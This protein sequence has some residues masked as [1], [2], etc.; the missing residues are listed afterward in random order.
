MAA[1]T[2][3]NVAMDN[4]AKLAGKRILFFLP[5]LE[6]GGAE[7]QALH[8]ARYL[9]GFGCDVRVWGNSG[10]GLA[11]DECD[12][13]GIPWAIQPSSWPCRKVHLVRCAWRLIKT[14]QA[15]RR[16]RPDVIFAYCA[17][18]CISS[19]LVWRWSPVKA[20]IWGQRDIRLRGDVVERL[21]YRRAS[22]VVCN[23]AHELDYLNRVLGKGPSRVYVVPNGIDIVPSQETR[24]ES[25]TRLGI[26]EDSLAVTM[27]ANFRSGK[28]HST[29]LHAWRRVMATCADLQ[30]PLR[31]VLA[32]AQQESYVAIH[33]LAV[34]LGLLQSVAFL[35]QVKD[36]AGLLA[37]SDVGVLA[38][39]DE[40][41]PN[42]VLEY[43][44][45][46]LPIIA[47]DIPGSRE[48]L[49]D[50]AD[51]QL[52]RAGD[53]ED[54][55][56]RLLTLIRSGELRQRLGERNRQRALAEFSITQMC[57]TTVGIIRDLLNGVSMSK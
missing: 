26:G 32:G 41:L 52:C 13:A 22:A 15:L 2:G 30:T 25:R 3:L 9:K 16:E 8:L 42:V 51:E 28:D 14:A 19:G 11:A 31:L 34:D 17:R 49:G 24:R 37:A 39:E 33:R 5:G 53:A 1:S 12:K 6:L 45:C 36:I 48:A 7:R 21:A 38:T 10:P 35:G 54:L 4:G 43:M 20:C 44:A 47:T 18:P 40:G 55:A 27:V 23:A 50:G 56:E 29:L 57:E 46:G